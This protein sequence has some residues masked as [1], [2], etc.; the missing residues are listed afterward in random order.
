MR[1]IGFNGLP[2]GILRKFGE[3]AAP[4]LEQHS[5][6]VGGHVQTPEQFLAGWLSHALEAR[7]IGRGGV[8]PV[9]LSGPADFIGIWREFLDQQVEEYRQGAAIQ[10]LISEQRFARDAITGAFSALRQQ[11]VTEGDGLGD[12]ARNAGEPRVRFLRS[13]AE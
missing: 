12:I 5:G 3:E 4:Q 7:E 1:K 10:G 13:K 11:A 8:F 2:L 6:A 9:S